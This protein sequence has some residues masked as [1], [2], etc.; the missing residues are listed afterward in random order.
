MFVPSTEHVDSIPQPLEGP[1]P[2]EVVQTNGTRTV[3]N[4]VLDDEPHAYRR[5]LIFP[6]G[7]NV[8][9]LSMYLDVADALSLPY[10]WTSQ[11]QFS[12]SVFNHIDPKYSVKKAHDCIMFVVLTNYYKLRKD[13]GVQYIIQ[14]VFCGANM[15]N[16]A[17]SPSWFDEIMRICDIEKVCEVAMLWWSLWK[18]CN[19]LVWHQKCS[20]I[21]AVVHQL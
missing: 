11:A 18:A 20:T 13:S 8:E 4:H 2:M 12:M 15:G 14:R 3:E 9:F 21:G 19:N 6:K 1:L 17:D 5:V 16:V 7:N 10:G